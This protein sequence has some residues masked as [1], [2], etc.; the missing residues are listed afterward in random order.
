MRYAEDLRP[1]STFRVVDRLDT[2][3]GVDLHGVAGHVV[4]FEVRAHR[5]VGAVREVPQQRS[6][7]FPLLEDVDQARIERI[8]A[9]VVCGA[10]VFLAASGDIVSAAVDDFG[11]DLLIAGK[12][13]V[14]AKMTRI[15]VSCV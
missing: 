12:R 10:T 15:R 9:P 8:D 14:P 1:G 11:A 7:A 4:A 13:S 5:L 6:F 2:N 3:G